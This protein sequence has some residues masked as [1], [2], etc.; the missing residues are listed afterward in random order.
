MNWLQ[1]SNR[2]YSLVL[3]SKCQI[4]HIVWFWRAF[5]SSTFV[6]FRLWIKM[7]FKWSLNFSIWENQTKIVLEDSSPS[8]STVSFRVSEFKHTSDEPLH[9]KHPKLPE[10]VKIH[11]MILAD[12][13]IKVK[14]RKPWTPWSSSHFI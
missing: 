1:M 5:K 13:R 9:L 11:D 4:D 2:S 3:T 6:C 14:L 8:F 10:I 7:K 12:R